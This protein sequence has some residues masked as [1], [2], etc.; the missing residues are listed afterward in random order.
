M[1]CR[2]AAEGAGL[3][4]GQSG[5]ALILRHGSSVHTYMREGRTFRDFAR[6]SQDEALDGYRRIA[7]RPDTDA[8]EQHG[9]GSDRHPCERRPY[10]SVRDWE[11][12]ARPGGRDERD[13]TSALHPAT[14]A[15][16]NIDDVARGM[17]L[18]PP[19]VLGVP[20]VVYHMGAYGW[21]SA[22]Q[23]G[24]TTYHVG[25]EK[26]SRMCSSQELNVGQMYGP[27]SR[28]FVLKIR[29]SNVG[30][31]VRGWTR[32][33]RQADAAT[34]V[35]GSEHHKARPHGRSLIWITTPGNTCLCFS[36]VA[37]V[38]VSPPS[39][40]LNVQCCPEPP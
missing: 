35:V 37:S 17:L 4:D 6:G 15:Y 5:A 32:V 3:A 21:F 7:I 19:G 22:S 29:V 2:V 30:R 12:R 25:S 40:R 24:G 36:A 9:S 31:S 1:D 10:A 16:K 14:V 38:L 20:G 18:R 26:D 28:T 27:A 34:G 39:P 33:E 23:P 8:R 11:G 13:R